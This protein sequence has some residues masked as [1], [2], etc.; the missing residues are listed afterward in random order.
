MVNEFEIIQ[1]NGKINT[2]FDQIMYPDK[3][4]RKI[5]RK[6]TEKNYTGFL[7]A[8]ISLCFSNRMKSITYDTTADMTWKKRIS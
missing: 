2:F 4:Q 7:F 1:L 8:Y 6:N 3:I 5:D